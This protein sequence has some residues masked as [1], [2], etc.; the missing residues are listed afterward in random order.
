MKRERC[1]F[2]T[3][4]LL[5]CLW[6]LFIFWHS[7]RTAEESS[8]ESGRILAFVQKFLPFITHTLLRKLGHMAEFTVLGGLL[9]LTLRPGRLPGKMAA[10]SAGWRRWGLPVGIGLLTA[11]CDETIQRFVPGRSA[12]V[13]DM[14]I[15]TAGALLGAALVRLVTAGKDRRGAGSEGEK[16]G[17]PAAK[18]EKTDRPA[19]EGEKT[20]TPA[21]EGEKAGRPADIKEDGHAQGK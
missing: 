11:V 6:I 17:G 1:R 4:F 7:L 15:D 14:L 18:G 12:E 2:Y 13:R 5:S 19:A 9:A 16:A 3:F 8:A 10:L 20:G 21:A